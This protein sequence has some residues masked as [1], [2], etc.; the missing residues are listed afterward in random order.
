MDINNDINIINL[1]ESYQMNNDLNNALIILD[2]IEP[3]NFYKIKINQLVRC[4]FGDCE[5]DPTGYDR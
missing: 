3:I 2:K 5:R 4:A 1:F